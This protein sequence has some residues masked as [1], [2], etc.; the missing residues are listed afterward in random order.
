MDLMAP[1][2]KSE[3]EVGPAPWSQRSFGSMYAEPSRN[4]IYKTSEFQGRGIRIVNMG[5][6]FGFEFIGNQD[7]SRVELTNQELSV[8][9]LRDGDLLFGRRS[10]V[11]AGAGK[12]S[13]IV[14]P[15]EPLTF[16]SS[17]IR[18]RLDRGKAH[19]LFYY[20]FF[21]SPVGRSLIGAIV[22]GTNVKGIR[23]T[24]LKELVV[25]HPSNAE[26]R[27][28]ATALADMDGLLGS[29][30]ALIAKKK[31]IKQGAMQQLL[32]GKQRL[33]GFDGEWVVKR[34]GEVVEFRT[35]GTPST[36][37]ASYWCG[38]LRWMNSGELNLKRVQEVEGRI[39]ELGLNESSTSLLPSHCVLIG[40]AGQGKT[41]GTAAI[42]LVPLCTN[43]SIAAMLPS[44]NHDPEFLYQL[45]DSKYDELRL[46]SDG[47]GGRGGLNLR[48][49]TS[50]ELRLPPSVQEQ[51]A[52]AEVLS[53]MDAEIGALEARR[54]KTALLKQGM[55]QELLTGRVRLV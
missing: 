47:G 25:P 43:Q 9:G 29:L 16:E 34:L 2:I 5:E 27:A 55:M 1:Q 20:Y 22:A 38:S 10:V 21:A 23:A 6:M 31:A 24:E 32:T 39:T 50:L 3:E 18:V 13:V 33:T 28:I 12:C 37:V 54:A 15:V 8:C 7:M 41:R 30:D 36:A 40:L 53:D 49:L 26:Q 45:M 4:G 44:K 19:P 42:N 48:S 17:I 52:I 11:P 51:T 14:S 35:G 46:L